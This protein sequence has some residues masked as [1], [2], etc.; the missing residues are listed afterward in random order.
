MV[1]LVLL[2]SL[3]AVLASA[4]EPEHSRRALGSRPPSATAPTP[5]PRIYVYELPECTFEHFGSSFINTWTSQ[6]GNP[7][8]IQ[9]H[10]RILG[11]QYVTADP[12]KASLF[13][14]PAPFFV[15]DNGHLCDLKKLP[16]NWTDPYSD[17]LLHYD[18]AE[19]ILDGNPL[20]V[21]ALPPKVNRAVGQGQRS[22]SFW[23]RL[24]EE[25][26]GEEEDGATFMVVTTG[27]QGAPE[28]GSYD[29]AFRNGRPVV[30]SGGGAEHVLQVAVDGDSAA[31][32]QRA[33][34][35]SPR[36]PPPMSRTGR[37]SLRDGRWH[38]VAATYDGSISRIFLD[39]VLF[40]EQPLV[41]SPR[42]EHVANSTGISQG[43]H[44]EGVV[45]DIRLFKALLQPKDVP[46]V[47][48][49]VYT[50]GSHCFRTVKA[51][52][53][54]LPWLKR[55]RGLDHFVLIGSS[56]Y[57]N[58]FRFDQANVESDY[59]LEHA[60]PAFRNFAVLS[61]GARAEV[62]A[63]VGL[64][65]ETRWMQKRVPRSIYPCMRRFFRIVTIPPFLQGEEFDCR[66]M[67][68]RFQRRRPIRLAYRGLAYYHMPERNSMRSA[69]ATS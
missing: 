42:P 33:A 47:H 65:E 59:V 56:E 29:V 44:L 28:G 51:H 63:S 36:L 69:A 12:A 54:A 24:P 32:S 9:I 4:G 58:C 17:G 3:A 68:E 2:G 45:R 48:G 1:A 34:S 39:G 7:P 43:Q 61:F 31:C 19:H 50:T 37:L 14:I 20:G 11:S 40:G 13:Y 41:L 55:R 23:A 22:I 46:H 25:A 66:E 8:T 67:K 60:W 49:G 16:Q 30:L 35:T 18:S 6:S 10:E 52:V 21:A 53:E 57:P 26:Q 64:T 15:W 38:H 5:T 27:D 62:C